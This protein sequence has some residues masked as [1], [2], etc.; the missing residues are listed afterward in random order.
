MTAVPLPAKVE[1][2]S[3][4]GGY[5]A[6]WHQPVK[7]IVFNLLE[8]VV[9]RDHGE[10]TWDDLLSSAG[11]TGAYTSLGSYPDE[12]FGRLV[13][14]A[15]EGLNVPSQDLVRWF[16]REAL[17]A[18]AKAYPGFFAQH[19]DTRSFLLTL[20]DIIHPEVR[21]SIRAPTFPT[22]ISSCCRTAACGWDTT[23]IERCVR[24]RKA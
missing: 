5:R 16:G 4:R 1:G 12:D 18:L 2:P 11:L 21:S 7:G 20:N 14:A 23:R 17:P 24:S 6:P 15:S 19:A 8:Q 13:R 9:T 3:S 22:S 10:N